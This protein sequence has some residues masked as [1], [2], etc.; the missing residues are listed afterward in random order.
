RQKAMLGGDTGAV[1][2]P[3]KGGESRLLHLAAGLDEET[4]PMP[5]EEMASPLSTEQIALLRT[6]IDQGAKWPDEFAGEPGNVP[7]ADHWSFQ[8]IVR[9]PIPEVKNAKWVRNPI[10]AFIL[11]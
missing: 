10:D 11:A 2:V 6:W 4:G 7:G 9:P 5:P 1:I 3:G 8:P